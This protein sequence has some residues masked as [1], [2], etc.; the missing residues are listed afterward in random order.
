MARSR[1][2]GG[3]EQGRLFFGGS[4]KEKLL[5]RCGL[6]GF[7]LK[8]GS[9]VVVIGERAGVQWVAYRDPGETDASFALKCETM[10]EALTHRPLRG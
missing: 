10:R 8:S 7:V 3:T 4:L 5:S 6:M 1:G 2:C 9:D